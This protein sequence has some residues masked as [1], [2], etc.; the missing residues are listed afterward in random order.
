MCSLLL[1]TS[2][3]ILHEFYLNSEISIH[4]LCFCPFF[5]F[6]NLQQIKGGHLL[7]QKLFKNVHAVSE[8]EATWSGSNVF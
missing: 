6:L 8:E 2:T 3:F 1:D 4:Y 5:I 7:M